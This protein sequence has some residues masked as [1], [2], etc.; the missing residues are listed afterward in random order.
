MTTERRSEISNELSKL[1]VEQTE[2]FKNG[3]PTHGEI[4]EFK[5]VGER[6]RKLFAELAREKQH[7]RLLPDRTC[8]Q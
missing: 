4:Q 5:R 8:A 3:H 1:L 7:E 2:F 6:I